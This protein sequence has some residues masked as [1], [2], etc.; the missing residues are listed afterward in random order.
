[1]RGECVYVC[2]CECVCVRVRVCECVYVCVYVCVSVCV[3]EYVCQ[4]GVAMRTAVDRSP[5][6]EDW[7]QQLGIRI[8]VERG[9]G[10]RERVCA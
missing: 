8:K 1:M 7:E 4:S 2:V 6:R 5:S 10:K 9:R 3:R